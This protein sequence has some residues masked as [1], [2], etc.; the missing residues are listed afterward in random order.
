MKTTRCI[1]PSVL[2]TA[3]LFAL[4]ADAL[5]QEHTLDEVVVTATRT[6]SQLE[7]TAA[8]V[9]VVT[10]KDIEEEMITGLDDLFDYTPGVSV[11]TNARQGVQSINIR[12]IEGNRIKVLVDGVSQ[13]NQ[14]DTGNNFI[15]SARVE[16]D[17]DM[18]KAV[19]VVKGAASSLHGSDAIGGI[20]AFETKDPSDFLKGREWG[21]HAKFNYSS[22]DN[23]FSESV[24]VANQTGGLESLVGYTREMATKLIT[25]VIRRMPIPAWITYWS[26]C[27]TNLMM[28]I[29]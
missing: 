23:T 1:K 15:N 2:A 16:V 24:A 21:G 3:I 4:S 7:D 25:L 14:F 10:D 27:R 8:S 18:I 22:D 13:G 20:V 26:N 9:A 5:A 17:T 11:Q 28:R 12:G 6:N 29:V 19:E